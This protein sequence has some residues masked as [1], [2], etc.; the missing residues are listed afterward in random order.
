MITVL[1][2]AALWS[3]V[4]VAVLP[5][6]L[7]GLFRTTPAAARHLRALAAVSISLLAV[8]ALAL[9]ALWVVWP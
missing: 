2:V 9:G 8:V 3:L 4:A 7:L 5:A 6:V 1:A